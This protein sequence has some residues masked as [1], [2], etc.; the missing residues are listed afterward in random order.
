[1]DNTTDSVGFHW[2]A[3]GVFGANTSYGFQWIP[4][5]LL[6][7]IGFQ[8]W[9]PW[10]PGNISA[11]NQGIQ[12]IPEE[13]M[14]SVEVQPGCVW[15]GDVLGFDDVAYYCTVA[16]SGDRCKKALLY[17]GVAVNRQWKCNL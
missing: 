16:K 7:S 3:N 1:M 5:N 8:M 17:I 11:I 14:D 15:K 12:W 13:S 9:S 4:W 6:E 10:S 2:I